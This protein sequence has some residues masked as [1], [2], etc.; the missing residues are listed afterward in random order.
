MTWLN[1]PELYTID[2]NS[3]LIE[4]Q[5]HTGF[6]SQ[7]FQQITAPGLKLEPTSNFAF[8]ARMRCS[9]EGSENECGVFL[10]ENT[11]H[12]MK[13]SLQ[14]LEDHLK[15]SCKVYQDG[16][17]DEA[18]REIGSGVQTMTLRVLYW[19]G[20][21]RFQYSFAGGTFSDMRWMH[22]CDSHVPLSAGI[23]ACS[24]GSH[25]FDCRFSEIRFQKI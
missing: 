21:I 11:G 18:V 1:R 5:P 20:N 15:I 7:T 13:G 16:Y 25:G 17:G 22:F 23:F 14:N 6:H 19:N 10:L 2:E 12:W 4:T 3:V 24:P 9:F 8:S